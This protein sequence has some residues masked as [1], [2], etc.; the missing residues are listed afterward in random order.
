MDGGKISLADG[1]H[2]T[3]KT[4]AALVLQKLF[5]DDEAVNWWLINAKNR[6]HQLESTG[7][8][9]TVLWCTII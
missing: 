5:M 2:G 4:H 6:C 1:A 3:G 8:E 7:S 9:E